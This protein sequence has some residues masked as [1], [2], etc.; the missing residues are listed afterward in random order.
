MSS[1]LDHLNQYK[2]SKKK[3]LN[4]VIETLLKEPIN[5]KIAKNPDKVTI[6]PSS[7]KVFKS[8]LGKSKSIAQHNSNQEEKK[9]VQMAR[10]KSLA[11]AVANYSRRKHPQAAN[12][13]NDNNNDT[14]NVTLRNIHGDSGRNTRKKQKVSSAEKREQLKKLLLQQSV[15]S[16]PQTSQE[17]QHGS[18][19][20]AVVSMEPKDSVNDD[21]EED[22]NDDEDDD[23][24]NGNENVGDSQGADDD[25]S[26]DDDFHTAESETGDDQATSS[27]SD[28]NGEG[29]VEED[30]GDD[31][32]VLEEL[33]DNSE[34]EEEE[35]EEEEEEDAN[36]EEE[37]VMDENHTNQ[38]AKDL[39]TDVLT[40]QVSGSTVETPPTSNNDDDER[41]KSPKPSTQLIANN[42][43]QSDFWDLNENPNDQGSNNSKRI[44]K[45]WGDFIENHIPL[46][47]VNHG[48]T[49]YM[50][51]AI[52]SISHIPSLTH[53]LID[54]SKGKYDKELKPD[55][56]T[57]VL[58]STIN[59]MYR[60]GHNKKILMINPKKLCK[61]LEDINCMM[62]EWQQEDSH[63]YFMSLM[64]R[65]QEDSTPKGVKLNQ[66]IIYDIFGG[67]LDQTVTCKNCGHISTTQQE[68]YDLSL[69]LENRKKR[70]SLM[71]EP[72][73][74]NQLKDQ[75]EN[76]NSSSNN[77][78]NQLSKILQQRILLAKRENSGSLSPTDENSPST[79]TINADSLKNP[80]DEN[81][82]TNYNS[83]KLQQSP[84]PQ[85][86]VPTKRYSLENAIRDFF[87]PEIL[88]TDKRDQSGYV[89][90]KC[91]KQSNAVKISTI[92]RA[93]ETLPVH[94]KRFR[95]DG[96]QSQK[97][98]ANVSYP[99]IL[100]LTPYTT[101][102]STPVRYKLISVI[103]HQGRSVSSGHYIT[104]CRQPDGTWA[105]YDDEYINK[106]PRAS[107][108]S[109][110]GAYVLF[111]ERLTSKNALKEP[112]FSEG[113]SAENSNRKKRKSQ[114]NKNNTKNKRRK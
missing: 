96:Q 36:D 73:Q 105:T 52:Q 103:V 106:I 53:Y 19:D 28:D 1:S 45:S 44:H 80:S 64:S 3:T 16:R 91:K 11:E 87:T 78:K 47:L 31:N 59:K 101:S 37:D 98:K 95:F 50:N 56:V 81:G 55:S 42:Y 79:E 33:Q 58:A 27:S 57:K 38:L 21:K 51:A 70:T 18:I 8:S 63:E 17:Q 60:I 74:L 68:F 49:C 107:A 69:G 71:V 35:E 113:T 15:E 86:S 54:V 20:S 112:P 82:S 66:S 14:A 85:E 97:V 77:E 39:K 99:E 61:R 29:D 6:K 24:S 114:P 48:V 72:Q 12:T 100:D 102:M 34:D 23:S 40:D 32:A 43:S 5:F 93:P 46:G 92:Q 94:L 10:P 2:N 67:L 83:N 13:N 26:S 111:Y 109:D 25:D 65:I 75:I 7:Y 110:P 62:S 89:C 9:K 30:S 76:C 22:S 84:D 104:H 88:R 108:L 4:P 90:E 41:G